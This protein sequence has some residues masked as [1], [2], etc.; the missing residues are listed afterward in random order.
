M[1]ASAKR[2][3]PTKDNER[4]ASILTIGTTT[5]F[6]YTQGRIKDGYLAENILKLINK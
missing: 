4:I 6:N 1:E 5:V 2:E 3:N